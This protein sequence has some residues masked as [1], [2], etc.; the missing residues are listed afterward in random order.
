MSLREKV[1]K[2][3]KMS[4][5]V[6]I[7]MKKNV[8]GESCSTLLTSEIQKILDKFVIFEFRKFYEIS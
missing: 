4:M 6:E 2:K 3:E 7:K 1:W 8:G 5:S